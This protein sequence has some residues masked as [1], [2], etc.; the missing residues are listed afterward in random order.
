MLFASQGDSHKLIHMK[1]FNWFKRSEFATVGK[2]IIWNQIEREVLRV[3]DFDRTDTTIDSDYK[4]IAK[5]N[6]TPY[7][8][9]ITEWPVIERRVK[10]PIVHQDDFLLASSIFDDAAFLK[11][12]QGCDILATYY[13]FDKKA[14]EISVFLHKLHFVITPPETFEEYY[15]IRNNSLLGC[16]PE[17]LFGEF[18]WMGELKVKINSEPKIEERH[19]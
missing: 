19:I 15:Q 6:I 13:P 18:D 5:S 14:N 7:G 2:E 17:V 10:V 1:I 8:F 4:V 9:L 12:I 11:E 16:N 3:I